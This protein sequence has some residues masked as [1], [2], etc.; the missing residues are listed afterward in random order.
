MQIYNITEYAIINNEGNP[1]SFM[2]HKDSGQVSYHEK[3]TPLIYD[4]KNVAELVASIHNGQ[5]TKVYKSQFL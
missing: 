4:D 2:L 3:G 1:L 5:V